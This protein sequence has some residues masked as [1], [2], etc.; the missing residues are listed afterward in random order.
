MT[1]QTCRCRDQLLT[2]TDSQQDDV[3]TGTSPQNFTLDC[4]HGD[5]V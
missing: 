3:I 5:D 1:M 2:D 4:E